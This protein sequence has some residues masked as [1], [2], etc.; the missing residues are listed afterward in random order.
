MN[1][2]GTFF[3]LFHFKAEA[4]F[5]AQLLRDGFIDGLVNVGHDLQLNQVRD[6][7]EGTALELF[8]EIAND[9]RWLER[10]NLAGLGRNKL[11]LLRRGRSCR[12]ALLAHAWAGLA[13]A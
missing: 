8:G 6:E 12:S 3:A 1:L 5:R 4:V 7:L 9:N 11:W 13:G 2:A 10:N